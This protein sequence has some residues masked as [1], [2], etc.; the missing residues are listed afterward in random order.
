MRATKHGDFAKTKVIGTV[1]VKFRG[2]DVVHD[3]VV[4]PV[5]YVDM[6]EE[7]GAVRRDYMRWWSALDYLRRHLSVD[8]SLERVQITAAM[9]AAMPWVA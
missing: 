8:R 6:P 5:T 2:R 1:T 9:P 3:L 4:C 7:V